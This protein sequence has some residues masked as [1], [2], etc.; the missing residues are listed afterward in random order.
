MKKNK[1]KDQEQKRKQRRL[2]LSRETIWVLNDPALLELARGRNLFSSEFH[3]GGT[4]S[5][6]DQCVTYG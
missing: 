2:S 3:C 6:W 4:T 5:G 1:T